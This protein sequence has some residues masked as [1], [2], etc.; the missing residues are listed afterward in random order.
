[1]I[2]GSESRDIDIPGVEYALGHVDELG[3]PRLLGDADIVQLLDEP[4]RAG[5]IHGL[6]HQSLSRM[7]GFRL[8]Y[9]LRYHLV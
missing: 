9:H 6:P 7:K 8:G 5:A 3:R 2:N 1:M 4:L